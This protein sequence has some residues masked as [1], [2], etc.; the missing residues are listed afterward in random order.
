MNR[1]VLG[2][3]HSLIYLVLAI[4]HCKLYH[5]CMHTYPSACFNNADT[6][7]I[8]QNM[9]YVW[10]LYTVWWKMRKSYRA[11][12]FRY[13]YYTF[14]WWKMRKSYRA[15][16]FR[17]D[18]ILLHAWWKTRKSYIIKNTRL[19]SHASPRGGRTCVPPALNIICIQITYA[20]KLERKKRP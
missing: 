9:V 14:V 2:C 1:L 18:Y 16:M 5:P 15:N 6:D 10:S 12:M 7:C 13:D 20:T 17:Y 19:L 8:M 11:S 3:V 4:K